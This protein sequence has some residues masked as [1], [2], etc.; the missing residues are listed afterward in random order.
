MNHEKEADAILTDLNIRNLTAT[1]AK[2][3]CLTAA[4][5]CEMITRQNGENSAFYK[6]NDDVRLG[7]L[8]GPN[9]RMK[10]VSFAVKRI[11]LLRYDWL[12]KFYK[13]QASM[14]KNLVLIRWRH[15][16]LLAMQKKTRYSTWTQAQNIK[17]DR[18]HMSA[19]LI[20]TKM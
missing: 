10:H 15:V 20:F 4:G 11:L 6:H 17:R 16:S 2:K 14:I 5:K 13:D 19:S 3:Y 9:G 18:Q 12:D 7:D 1:F 8:F